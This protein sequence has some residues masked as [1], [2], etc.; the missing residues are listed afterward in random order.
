LYTFFSQQFARLNALIKRALNTLRT[1]FSPAKNNHSPAGEQQ[2]FFKN[3]FFYFGFLSLVLLVLP[4]SQSGGLSDIAYQKNNALIMSNSFFKSPDAVQQEDLFFSQNKALAIE[5]PDLKIIQDS[6]IY[7]VSTPQ[8]FTAQ[9]LGATFAD[10]GHVHGE[11][12]PFDVI[13]EEGD[14]PE[15]IA[16]EY[17]ISLNTVLWVNNISKNSTLKVGQ[18][19]TVL[20]V[21]GLVHIVKSGDT[22]D[23][24]SKTYKANG[25]DVVAFN[26]LADKNDVF[27]GDILV[28]P[29]GVM[30]VKAPVLAQVPL[31]NNFFIIPAEGKK[32]QG[33][34]FSNA[35]DI[36]NKCGTPIY[37]A[38][39][40][41]VQRARY[42]WN[43]GGG[44]L[45]TILHSNG[46]VSYYGHLM[47]IVVKSGD[48]VEVGQRI[49]LMGTTGISTGCHLHFG[50]TGAKNPLA[51]YALGAIL[52]YK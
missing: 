4:F 40:G 33:L 32:T 26:K 45:V 51:G 5:T 37:A 25:D 22:I 1:L 44:N 11:D 2:G 17:N 21:S 10:L 42:G 7:S 18:T 23:G 52:K 24:L 20:P 48:T 16:K 30:P 47:T 46:T 13:V 28:V 50:V 3:P 15:S 27:V 35:I 6:F 12:A 29:N 9:T 39:S 41:T 36:G 14:T 34:H 38:A 31:A 8:I 49:G 19:L 43:S